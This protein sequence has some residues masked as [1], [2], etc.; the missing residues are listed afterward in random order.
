VASLSEPAICLNL[1]KS[2]AAIVAES[3]E[4]LQDSH[5]LFGK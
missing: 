5:T 3:P 4:A 1:A 2:S